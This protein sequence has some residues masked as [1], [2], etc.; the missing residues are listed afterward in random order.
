VTD[1]A[2]NLYFTD[3]GNDRV[4]KV[5]AGQ[6]PFS[7]TPATISFRATA[8]AT[9]I[10]PKSFAVTSPVSGLAWTAAPSGEKPSGEKWLSI[11]PQAGSTPASINV[12]VSP[13]G[14][15]PG[16]YDGSITITAP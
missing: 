12:T 1:S 4:R 8:D 13:L 5:L 9:D 11:S 16:K 3:V 6:P 7:V 10:F 14:L 2:G 15:S